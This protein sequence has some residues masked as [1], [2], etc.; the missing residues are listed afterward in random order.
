MSDSEPSHFVKVFLKLTGDEGPSSESLWA[1]PLRAHDGGGTYRLE[2]NTIFTMLMVGDIVRAEIDGSS[3]L[4]VTGVDK[5]QEGCLSYIQYSE[6]ETHEV[7]SATVESLSKNGAIYTEGGMGIIVTSWPASRP[8]DLIE[9]I[10]EQT[11][12]ADWNVI[13][14]AGPEDRRSAIEH[15]LDL[16]L[17]R[18]SHQPKI[19]IGYWA[20]DDPAWET[21]GV[22]DPGA[23][24]Y[25]QT[26]ASDDPRVLATIRSGRHQDVLTFAQRLTAA[27]P[28]SLPPLHRPLLV[29][30][31]DIR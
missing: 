3:S 18:S 11:I 17:D 1:S 19:T 25:I 4:Q 31:E 22:T 21:L 5:L 20:P 28:L 7:I 9:Q 23:L 16:K 15:D 26:L 12:P 8:I 10:L 29:D 6:G 2:N 27:D 30:P 24:A 13:G 14:V